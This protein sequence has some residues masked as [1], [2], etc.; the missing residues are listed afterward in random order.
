MRALIT[1]ASLAL[2]APV[3][4]ADPGALTGAWT[5]VAAERDGAAAEGLLGHRLE[6]T[7]AGFAITSP[8]GKLPYGGTYAVDVAAQP[9]RIDFRHD[10]GEAAGQTWEGIY[11]LAGQELMTVDDVV[12]PTKGRPTGFQADPGSGHVM[13]TFRR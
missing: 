12:D 1:A 7:T 13:I 2:T 8:A 3:L 11:R 5:A 10:R 9:A 6:L 4:A